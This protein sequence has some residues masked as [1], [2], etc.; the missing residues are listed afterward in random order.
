MKATLVLIWFAIVMLTVVV[1]SVGG[2]ISSHLSM[3][4]LE[5]IRIANK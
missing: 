4:E 5:M 1:G 3:I 2:L